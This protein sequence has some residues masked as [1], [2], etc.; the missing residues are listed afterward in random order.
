[1]TV[2]WGLA[3]IPAAFA[4]I[5]SKGSILET[6][7]AV[8]SH[9]IGAML[10]MYNSRFFSKHTTQKRLLIGVAAEF[11][12]IYVLEVRIP[13]TDWTPL[14]FAWP[15]FVVIGSGV[16]VVVSLG[17]DFLLS[18]RQ[19]ERPEYTVVDQID[20]FR[21]QNLEEKDGDWYIVPGKIDSVA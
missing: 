3:V 8:G 1:M 21:E 19:E 16:D 12:G 14:K 2:L 15:W 7:T 20:K 4:L 9:C 10:A 17:A 11:V 18:E 5:E 13:F 6:V